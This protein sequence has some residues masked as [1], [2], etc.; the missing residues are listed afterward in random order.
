MS[1]FHN[2]QLLWNNDMTLFPT[3][4]G[5]TCN[6]STPSLLTYRMF[7]SK[8]WIRGVNRVKNQPTKEFLSFALQTCW[9]EL[10]NPEKCLF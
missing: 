3:N 4:E 10:F 6:V 1:L 8:Q 7:V 9:W 5:F 2:R